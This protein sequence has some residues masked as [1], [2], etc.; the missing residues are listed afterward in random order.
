MLTTGAWRGLGVGMEVASLAWSSFWYQYGVGGLI[1][2]IGLVYTVRQG[3]VGLRAGRP[4]RN[5]FML[6]GGFLAYFGVH[7]SM[8]L[9]G[10]A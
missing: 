1:F 9:I 8:M 10:S 7:L 4:R 6:L 3:E 2:L 5:L